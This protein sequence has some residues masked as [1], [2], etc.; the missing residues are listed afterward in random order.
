VVFL[1]ADRT[2]LLELDQA[3]RYFLAWQSIELDAQ[4]DPPSLNLDNFQKRQTATQKLNSDATAKA[5][6]PE[7]FQWLLVPTQPDP[8]TSN[9]EWQ[10]IRVQGQDPLAV[11]VSKKLRNDGLLATQF[12]SNLLR[13]ELDRIPLWRGNHVPVKQAV[14]D[15][16]Q[17]LCLQRLKDPD[18]LLNAIRDGVNL[19]T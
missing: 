16:A 4:C 15:F 5:R 19:M 13:Q 10:A 18:V 1:A 8:K 2:R 17:Y 11:R 9:V 3:V 14:E 12:G 7:T 6:I